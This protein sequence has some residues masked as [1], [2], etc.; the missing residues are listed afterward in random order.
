MEE[1]K[2]IFGID[3]GTTYSCIAHLNK[4]GEP[5]VIPNSEG[6]LI[7]PSVIYF[8]TLQNVVVGKVAKM[9][10]D[11]DPKRVVDFVK[12]N[13]GD[14]TFS[15]EIDGKTFRAEEL[16]A[17][18]L[19]KLVQDASTYLNEPV[20][21]VVITCP[22]YFGIRERMATENAGKIA[23]LTVH[24]VVN[25]PTAAAICYGIDKLDKPQTVLVYDL[26]GGTFDI[27]MIDVNKDAISTITTGGDHQLGGKD[28]D[29]RIIGYFATSFM[30]KYGDGNDPRLD[31]QS[32]QDLRNKAEEAKKILTTKETYK[33]VVSFNQQQEKIELTRKKFEELTKD[34]L[35]RTI[36]L[37]K[38][39][40][41]NAKQTGHQQVD[42]FLM[43]GGSSRMPM[44]R[45]AIVSDLQMDPII[46]EPDMAVAKGAAIIGYY[47]KQLLIP[48][49]PGGTE[50]K[51]PKT[52]GPG[53]IEFKNITSKAFG[54]VLARRG[55]SGQD[56]NYVYFI[57]PRHT[58]L[59]AEKN[60]KGFGT[61][62]ANQR[63]VKIDLMEQADGNSEPS[64][65]KDD[66]N[67]IGSGT[68]EG[69]PPN[70]PAN[71]PIEITFQIKEDGTLA[72]HALCLGKEC[73]INSQVSGVMNEKELAD[74]IRGQSGMTIT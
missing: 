30:E 64:E 62:T 7:T 38:L 32:M 5:E 42:T 72:L 18:I 68:I 10:A 20:T 24:G 36:E 22:A 17:I 41:E 26:G 8:E 11:Q 23:G 55:S 54:V 21:D 67:S 66:N 71:S 44:V 4:N 14:E 16:S 19:K 74:A 33:T 3:L 29:D 28:W 37:S 13:I 60:E 51:G 45:A 34:L 56:E 15:Y 2:K 47:K 35:N 49:P 63:S 57:L 39:L 46:F 12:R 31:P 70:L 1:S 69:L 25:E 48:T 65:K 59:P 27:T 6:D 52:I 61:Y 40:L 58:Q 9:S 53:Q 50:D 43:V 73:H